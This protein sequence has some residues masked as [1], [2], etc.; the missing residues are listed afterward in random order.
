MDLN[1][2]VLIFNFELGFSHTY[3]FFGFFASRYDTA[4][5]I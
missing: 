1:G 5:V 3:I 2:E 4:I